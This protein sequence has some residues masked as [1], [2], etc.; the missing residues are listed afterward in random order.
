MKIIQL[1]KEI[2]IRFHVNGEP[3][4][5][6]SDE[7]FSTEIEAIEQNA[8]E[9]LSAAVLLEDRMIEAVSLI[10][11]GALEENSN[12]KQ[13]FVDEI[14]GTS[15]FSY[16]FKRRVFTRLLEASTLLSRGE[17]K[18]LKSGLNKIM[19]W[20]NAFAHGQII[21]EHSGGFLLGY[22]CGG[23]KEIILD[24]KYFETVELTIRDCLYTCNG[25]IQ[26]HTKN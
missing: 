13:F 20:R 6:R 5:S 11:F 22:Y 17:V 19:E 23:P 15:D 3:K 12:R 8:Y 14:I 9:I 7:D 26:S 24:N 16:S 21:H 1:P 2:S 18:K 4:S 10:L 25:V